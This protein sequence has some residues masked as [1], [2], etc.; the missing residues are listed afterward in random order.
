MA[1][2]RLGDTTY[3]TL[4]FDKQI[5]QGVDTGDI[6]EILSDMYPP[7]QKET[8]LSENRDLS[9]FYGGIAIV[10]LGRVMVMYPYFEDNHS[11]EIFLLKNVCFSTFP[12]I[13]LKAIPRV[14]WHFKGWSSAP[15]SVHISSQ[16]D[17]VIF[18]PDYPDITGFVATFE[19]DDASN[20]GV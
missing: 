1:V 19:E 6:G 15:G 7:V 11:E 5:W 10:G 17:L 3:R 14:G 18:E 9:W 4:Q 12:Y 8:S 20:V 13:Y 16:E 2:H